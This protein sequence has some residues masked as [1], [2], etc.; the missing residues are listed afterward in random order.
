[1]G[2]FS[3]A[4][5]PLALFFSTE[6]QQSA[7]IFRVGVLATSVPRQLRESLRELGYIEGRNLVL[8]VRETEGRADRVDNL[9]HE[10]V[11]L[12]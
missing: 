3:V 2:C 10:L 5:S 1:L 6:A 4:L 12:M 8:E 7:K 11:L 9:A